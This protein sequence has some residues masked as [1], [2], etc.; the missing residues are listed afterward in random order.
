[1]PRPT[2]QTSSDWRSGESYLTHTKGLKGHW[3]WSSLATQ[4]THGP[5][6]HTAHVERSFFFGVHLLGDCCAQVKVD[7]CWTL[8]GDGY[9]CSQ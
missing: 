6:N 3:C 2:D 1:M 9:L 7:I 5:N 4:I 8:H